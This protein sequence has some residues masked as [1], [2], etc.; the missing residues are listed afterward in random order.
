VVP[1]DLHRRLCTVAR[2]NGLAVHLDGARIFN[3]A[4]AAGVKA[5]SFAEEVDSLMFCLSKGLSCPLGS[6]V[7]G[8]RSFIERADRARKRVGGGMRQAGIIAAAGIVALESMI[9]RLVEDHRNARLLAEGLEEIPGL[10][11]DL[12]TVETNMV[13]V[14]HSGTGMENEQ[15]MATLREAGVLVSA[16]PPRHVRFVTNRHHDRGVIEEALVRTKRAL[17]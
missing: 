12:D 2:E 3:A 6:I 9:D 11:V 14:D 16:R 8:S 1:L 13:L 17:S 4:I 5:R 15:F 7:V 10:E